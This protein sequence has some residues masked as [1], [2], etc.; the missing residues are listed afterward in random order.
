MQGDGVDGPP[1]VFAGSPLSSGVYVLR[2]C[3]CADLQVRFGRYAGGAPIDVPAGAYA[4]VGSALASRGST[5]LAPRLLR[6]ATRS[7]RRPPH[8]IR[9]ELLRAC[10]A[11]GLPISAPP[12]HKKLFWNIDYLLDDL[13]AE[14]IGVLAVRALHNLE[15]NLARAL[16]ALPGVAPLAPRLGAH[17]SHEVAHLVRI[18]AHVGW[19]HVAAARL[20]DETLQAGSSFSSSFSFTG[21]YDDAK[22]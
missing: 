9:A 18:P 12:R 7:G 10:V 17:D 14:I 2:I 20:C 11:A 1:V 5:A 22:P 8:A 15:A 19:W 4:Y 6:H 21:C 3:V 16:L 13:S